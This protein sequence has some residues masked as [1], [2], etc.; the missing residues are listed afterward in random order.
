MFDILG[1]ICGLIVNIDTEGPRTSVTIDTNDHD[2]SL[3]W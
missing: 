1:E 2:N 3:P